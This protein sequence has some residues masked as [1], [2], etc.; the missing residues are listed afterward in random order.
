MALTVD[1]PNQAWREA[2][3]IH[4][5]QKKKQIWERNSKQTK[6]R[7]P[8]LEREKDFNNREYTLRKDEKDASYLREGGF[9]NFFALSHQCIERRAVGLKT[10]RRIKL[11]PTPSAEN[12][13]RSSLR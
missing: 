4:A 6:P 7:Q 9:E 10:E 12:I 11:T 13:I 3:E 2:D 5:K 1:R 8:V